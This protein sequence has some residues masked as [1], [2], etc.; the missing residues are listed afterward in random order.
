[1]YYP[2]KILLA[3]ELQFFKMPFPVSPYTWVSPVVVSFPSKNMSNKLFWCRHSLLKVW[4]VS[5]WGRKRVVLCDFFYWVY[6]VLADTFVLKLEKYI[7][8]LWPMGKWIFWPVL[9]TL[10]GWYFTVYSYLGRNWETAVLCTWSHAKCDVW[11][12]KSRTCSFCHPW[13]CAKRREA[14]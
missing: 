12:K 6:L 9:C 7:S 1:M 13:A 5:L 8:S 3:A 4:K 14:C 10:K 11:G 2:P